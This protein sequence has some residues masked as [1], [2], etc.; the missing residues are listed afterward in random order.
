M[1]DAATAFKPFCSSVATR[2]QVAPKPAEHLIML[3]EVAYP[4]AALNAQIASVV[5]CLFDDYA[6]SAFKMNYTLWQE[7]AAYVAAPEGCP[8][9]AKEVGARNSFNKTSVKQWVAGAKEYAW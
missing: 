6:L 4:N 5:V 2:W 3:G 1:H 8:Q 7:F 9:R